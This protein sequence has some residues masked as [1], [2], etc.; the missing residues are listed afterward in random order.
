[1]QS[2]IPTAP[3][4]A[5]LVAGGLRTATSVFYNK[6]AR[7]EW[8]EDHATVRDKLKQAREEVKKMTKTL[9]KQ[10]NVNIHIKD[11]L[12]TVAA[13]LA[14][15][16]TL[17][18]KM[19]ATVK[20]QPSQIQGALE[21]SKGTPGARKRARVPSDGGGNTP[22]KK[23]K[24]DDRSTPSTSG[25]QGGDADGQQ[26]WQPAASRKAKKKLKENQDRSQPQN[27][28]K[29]ERKA[30]RRRR[31]AILIKPETRKTKVDQGKGKAGRTEYG[32]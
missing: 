30:P 23:D 31:D 17:F 19:E 14:E 24:K 18:D 25:M 28:R 15:A 9:A 16:L 13:I 7:T 27:T 1:M 4:T 2:M 21:E 20:K 8:L 10:R 32:G 11:G 29:A 22:A 26:P 6:A 5:H 3:A 12:P